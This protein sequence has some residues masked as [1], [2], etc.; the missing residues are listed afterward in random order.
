MEHLLHGVQA[1]S[2]SINGAALRGEA[3]R[4]WR[5]PV[6][7]PRQ[8]TALCLAA[9]RLGIREVGEAL[10]KELRV[11]LRRIIALVLEEDVLLV[12]PVVNELPGVLEVHVKLT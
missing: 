8:S 7:V 6:A 9:S 1:T 2:L 12:D 3:S 4:F 10:L 11:H 5:C